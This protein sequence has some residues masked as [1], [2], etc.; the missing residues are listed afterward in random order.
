VSA[1]I[2]RVNQPTPGCRGRLLVL[3]ASPPLWT[4][5]AIR[6]VVEGILDDGMPPAARGWS[7]ALVIGCAAGPRTQGDTGRRADRGMPTDMPTTAALRRLGGVPRRALVRLLD[8]LHCRRAALGA[9]GALDGKKMSG[10]D[11]Q[12]VQSSR[13]YLAATK[14]SGRLFFGH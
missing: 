4:G 9:L 10:P 12:A 14:R 3:L 13:R 2:K 6:A 5:C 1:A 8:E 7:E 11:V